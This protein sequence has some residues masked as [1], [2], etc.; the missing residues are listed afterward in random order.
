[1][2][3]RIDSHSAINYGCSAN[4]APNMIGSGHVKGLRVVIGPDHYSTILNATAIFA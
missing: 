4:L 1:M 2:L 3:V